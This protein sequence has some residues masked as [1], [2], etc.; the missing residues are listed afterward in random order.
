MGVDELVEKILKVTESVREIL[1]EGRAREAW[2][3]FASGYVHFHLYCSRYQLEEV[4]PEY[5]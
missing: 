3:S 4:V 5:F 2:E 1:G